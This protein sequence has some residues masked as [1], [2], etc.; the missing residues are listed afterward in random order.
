VWVKSL[1]ARRGRATDPVALTPRAAGC[2]VL[3]ALLDA[4]FRLV[5]RG[6]ELSWRLAA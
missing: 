5:R 1:F 4:G 6:Y 3:T 2:A